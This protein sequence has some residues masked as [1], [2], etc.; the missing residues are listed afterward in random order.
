MQNKLST[1]LTAVLALVFPMAAL[2]DFSNTQTISSGQYL[3]LATG[4]TSTSGGDLL[5]TGTS[6]TPQGSAKFSD[7]SMGS[8]GSEASLEY[9]LITGA[10]VSILGG[11]FTATPINGSSLVT[12]EIF[13]VH[14]NGGYYAKV[15]IT[16]VSKTS[17]ALEY[18][19]FGA[20]AGGNTPNITAV[21]DAGGYT[22]SVAE[23]SIFVVKGSNMS[24]SGYT[25]TSYPLPA[26]FQN[27]SIAFTPQTGAGS[28]TAA[29]IV[30]LYNQGGV[31]QLAAI[32]PSTLAVGYYNVTVTYNG[33]PSSPYL[34]QVVK[35]KPGLLTADSTG[36]GLVLDQNYISQTEYDINRFT[37]GTLYGD[38]ISPGH[39]GQTMIVW[40]TGLGPVPFADNTASPAYNFAA[41]GQNIQVLVNGTAITPFY[42]GSAPGLSAIDQVDF[43]LPANV[44]TGC[45]VP[46]QISENGILS[47][48]T[49]I[50][51]AL[52]GANA[53]VLPGYTTAQLQAFDNGASV[54]SGGFTISQSS[55]NYEG[56][57]SSTSG[58][59]G[60]FTQYTGFEISAAPAPVTITESGCVVIQITPT[61]ATPSPGGKGIFLDAGK[62]TLT[63]PAGSS[64]NSTQL[65]ETINIYDLTLS[66]TGTPT[67]GTIVA[68]T[69]T[70]NAAGG[71]G[72]GAFNATVTLGAPFVVTGGL[73][74][75]VT[76]GAGLTFNW[77][78]GNPSD[79]VAIEGYAATGTGDAQTGAIFECFTNAGAKTFTVSSSI[80]NQ[81]PAITAAAVTAGTAVGSLSISSS[82]TPTSGDGYFNAPLTAGGSIAN[83]TF[84]GST[85]IS[86]L[87]AY[88]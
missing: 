65:P 23:G 50:S 57:A 22:A 62:V 66:A 1:T 49:F 75:T 39:P 47:Q 64:L 30:Y 52:A 85:L 45:T 86:G 56:M 33:N 81:L 79:G 18:D 63:G 7:Y 42:A 44:A 38:T 11:T 82:V 16:A 37:T 10:D 88:Q 3:N 78:G 58:A 19:T 59:S 32:L 72:V 5:F 70:L 31:N 69:Y 83:A 24:I 46:L 84:V 55:E 2:A 14:T 48:P 28:P 12:G 6:I 20:P 25:T 8:A 73:P 77:T 87:A 40:M 61:V 41:N 53:C 4:A 15:W 36:N 13:L 71:T 74:S 34:V 35:Q 26:N 76:R 29:Y 43:V 80:L 67:I 21:L 27:T 68:G 9:S 54:T 60:L 51:I 17:L